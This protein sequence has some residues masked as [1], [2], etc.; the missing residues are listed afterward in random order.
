VGVLKIHRPTYNKICVMLDINVPVT[1]LMTPDPPEQVAKDAKGFP[2]GMSREELLAGISGAW[3]PMGLSPDY[4][5]DQ[6]FIWVRSTQPVILAN[7]S[8]VH[9][10]VHAGQCERYPCIQEAIDVSDKMYETRLYRD[11]PFELEAEYMA[12]FIINDLGYRPIYQEEQ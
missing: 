2:E 3:G 10:M 4:P 11:H 5:A 9:E 12:R 6:H 7:I 8:L 1:L